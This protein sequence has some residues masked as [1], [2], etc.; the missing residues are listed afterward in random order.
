MS[1]FIVKRRIYELSDFETSETE[2]FPHE[3]LQCIHSGSAEGWFLCKIQIYILRKG[4][5]RKAVMKAVIKMNEIQQKPN[6][7]P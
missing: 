4:Y 7:N 2:N 6:H 3:V 5:C 1:K